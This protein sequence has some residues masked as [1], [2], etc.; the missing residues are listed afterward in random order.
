MRTIHLERLRVQANVGILEHELRARQLLLVS[1]VAELPQAPALP[2]TDEVAAV[3]DYRLLRGIALEEVGRGHV[4]MLETLAGRIAQRVLGLDGAASLGAA[5]VARAYQ[6]H[7]I[8]ACDPALPFPDLAIGA[9]VRIAPNH[10]C[11][12]AAAHD[13]YHVVDGGEAVEAIW[14]RVNYW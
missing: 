13:R 2:A 9:L 1:I 8:V 6:E 14:P 12:T 4:N 5:T 3:L 10:A 7:G 11:L